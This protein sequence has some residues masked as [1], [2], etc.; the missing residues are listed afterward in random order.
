[1]N[2]AKHTFLKIKSYFR[3]TGKQLS[4]QCLY[5]MCGRVSKSLQ[6]HQPLPQ[7]L[8]SIVLHTAQTCD[9]TLVARITLLE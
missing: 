6:P 7:L 1:M 8:C 4:L 5:V 3:D 9:L 2:F